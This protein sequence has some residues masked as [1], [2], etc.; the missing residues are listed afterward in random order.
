VWRVAA[1]A[2]GDSRGCRCGGLAWIGKTQERDATM[3]DRMPETGSRAIKR[4]ARLTLCVGRGRVRTG[5]HNRCR[6]CY[7]GPVRRARESE[8][9]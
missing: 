9:R 7:N 5:L 2:V 1:L 8:N 6:E 4:K 3:N